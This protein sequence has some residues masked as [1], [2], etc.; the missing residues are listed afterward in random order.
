MA[1]PV[2]ARRPVP[3]VRSVS[4]AAF[5]IGRRP[6]RAS[7]HPVEWS[8]QREALKKLAASAMSKREARLRELV[9]IFPQ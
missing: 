3:Q 5:I 6:R 9:G 1:A 7:S 4:Y 8:E 2:H